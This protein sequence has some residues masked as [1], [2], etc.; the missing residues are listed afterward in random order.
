METRLSNIQARVDSKLKA[1]ADQLFSELGISTAD[2][3]RMFL[4]QSVNVNGLPFQPI[5]K[6][7]NKE[8][9]IAIKEI[10]EG[11]ANKVSSAEDLYKEL[12]I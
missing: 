12:S 8:T 5:I 1:E 10:E 4:K 6:T 3:V 2:A 7:P 11:R 9:L